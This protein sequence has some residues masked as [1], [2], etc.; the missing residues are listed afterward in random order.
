[1]TLIFCQFENPFTV[2]DAPLFIANG[3]SRVVELF[4]R[5]PNAIEPLL[6]WLSS[7]KRIRL[8]Q[9][10][11]NEQSYAFLMSVA[12][13]LG[14]DV[15]LVVN[16]VMALSLVKQIHKR[17]TISELQKA[18]QSYTTI[19]TCG[20]DGFTEAL[21]YLINVLSS[22]RLNNIASIFRRHNC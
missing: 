5:P 20:N 2:E 16:E 11:T 14:I 15:L 1:M 9:W 8:P 21:A 10:R 18:F 17:V 3:E 12:R 19:G 7:E 4:G 22:V 13:A 6:D